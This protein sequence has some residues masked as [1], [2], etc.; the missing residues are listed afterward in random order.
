MTGLIQGKDVI[1]AF[2]K[3][4]YLPFVCAQDMSVTLSSDELPIRTR[5]KT[6]KG[7][8]KKVTYQNASYSI[9]LSGLLKFDDDNFTGWDF[10]D[11][12]LNFAHVDFKLTFVDDQGNERSLQGSAMV[13]T[14]TLNA[15]AGALVKAQVDLEG[16]GELMIF[17]GLIAC[18][19]TIT[20]ISVAGASGGSGIVTITYTYT[21]APYQ[22][23][24]R[25]N[26]MGT[27][28]YALLGTSI[29]TPALD[30][31]NYSIEIIPVCENGYEADNSMSQAFMVTRGG[32]CS[33]VCTAISTSGGS[34]VPTFTGSPAQWEYSIDGAAFTVVS[35]FIT[36]VNISGLSVGPHTVSVNPICS[37][38]VRGTGIVNQAF[39]VTLSPTNSLIQWN[40]F[41]ITAPDNVLQI[42]VNGVL[43]VSVNGSGSH[44]GSFTAPI[45]ATIL[46]TLVINNNS[47]QNGTLTTVDN[48]IS[49]VLDT[50]SHVVPGA[51][52]YSFVTNGDT[53]TVGAS[54]L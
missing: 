3:N 10:I 2:A 41:S 28:S 34:L 37:N 12:W 36:A 9:S 38:N 51:V 48:T 45:G 21:G 17:D 27:Y 30:A 53:F 46:A 15:S 40:L 31:G 50:R 5:T 42:F 33:A 29:I 19:S 25:L 54:I 23:K 13:K 49:S 18:D 39:T 1:L 24:Y 35:A 16:N 11:N 6:G 20:G 4:D 43:N 47:G 7:H 14:N 52:S 32:T 26:G 44:S 22:V 8:W